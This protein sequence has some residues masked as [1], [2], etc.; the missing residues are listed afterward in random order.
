[1]APGISLLGPLRE[2]SEEIHE[3]YSPMHTHV[4][5][6]SHVYVQACIHTDSSDSSPISTGLVPPFSL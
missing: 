3:V 2:Q 1:M 6:L 4:A 5:I